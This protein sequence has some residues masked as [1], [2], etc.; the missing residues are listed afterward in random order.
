MVNIRLTYQTL[1][2]YGESGDVCQTV[3]ERFSKLPDRQATAVIR[4]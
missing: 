3:S 2:L 1:D 4:G